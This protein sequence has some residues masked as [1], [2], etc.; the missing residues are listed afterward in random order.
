MEGRVV[1]GHGGA[2]P[3]RREGAARTPQGLAR[4]RESPSWCPVLGT[5]P[6]MEQV[7]QALW[8]E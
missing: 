4:D 1:R 5:A 3:G 2:E 8:S 7:H 6:G